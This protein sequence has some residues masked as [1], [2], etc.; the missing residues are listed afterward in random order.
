MLTVDRRRVWPVATVA[1]ALLILAFI[2]LAPLRIIAR[3]ALVAYLPGLAIWKRIRPASASL[4]DALLYPS[5]LSLLPFAWVSFIGVIFGFGLSVAGWVAIAFFVAGWLWP[6]RGCGIQE[7][8]GDRIAIGLSL[9]S[10]PPNS[11]AGT[12]DLRR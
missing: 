6:S 10:I 4:V 7:Q 1:L 9:T 12:I 2:P 5:L 11:R 3:Y 8:N